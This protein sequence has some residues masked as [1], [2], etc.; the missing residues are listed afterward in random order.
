MKAVVRVV[1]LK[2][3]PWSF[4][5]IPVTTAYSVHALI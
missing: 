4:G 3:I 2:I 5:L 1:P